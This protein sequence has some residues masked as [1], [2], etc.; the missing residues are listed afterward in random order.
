MKRTMIES[1]YR[2]T[3]GR[4]IADN[5]SYAD[6][7]MRDSLKRGEAPFA[8]HLLYPFYLDDRKADERARGIACG[9]AWSEAAELVAVYCDNGISHGMILAIQQAK[10]RGIKVEL[11]AL[12]GR[13][14]WGARRMVRRL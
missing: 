7:A 5:L 12:R 14:P 11:R 13:V 9:L 6:E 8:M 10:V 1:P 2:A 4:S 3:E